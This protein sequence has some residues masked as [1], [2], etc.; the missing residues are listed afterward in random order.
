MR[1]GAHVGWKAGCV[2]LLL[3]LSMGSLA[4]P[5]PSDPADAPHTL[6]ITDRHGTT[7]RT[8]YPNGRQQPVTLHDVAPT[9]VQALIATEDRRFYHHPGIDPLSVLDAARA[10]L[11]AGRVVRG[12]STLTMQVARAM[13]PRSGSIWIDKLAEAHLALRLELRWSKTQILEAWL[14][15]VSF[16]NR[17]HG[18]EAA[19][20]LYFGTSARDLTPQQST[21]LVGL[22]QSPSRYNP[23]RYPDRARA[24]QQRVLRALV[25]S[26]TLSTADSTAWANIPLRLRPP[27]QTMRAPHFTTALLAASDA[28]HTAREW[29]TT[30]DANLQARIEARVQTRLHALRHQN[31]T[32]AAV[33]VLNNATGAIRAYVGSGDFWDANRA[34]Q[35]DGVRMHRQPGS[36]LKPFLYGAAFQ[37]GRY[38]PASILPD[39]PLHVPE[40]GGAF[41]PTNYDNRF[42]GPVSAREALAASY[43]VPAVYLAR[44]MGTA[45]L[46]GTLRDVGFA[47]L[48]RTPGHYGVGLALGNGEVQLREL[49]EAYAALARGGTRP[50]ATAYTWIRTAAGDTLHVEPPAPASTPLTPATAAQLTDMLADAEARTPAFGASTPLQLPFPVAVKTGTSK[51]YRDNWTVG[52]T[53]TH[54]VA[55]WVGNFDG[56]PMEQVSG[57]SGAGPLFHDVMRMLGPGGAFPEAAALEEADICPASGQ[58]PGA[59]CPIAR[60]ERFQPG[61]APADTC[62]VHRRIAIDR[63]TGARASAATPAFRVQE[64][65]YAVHPPAYHDW[66]RANGLPLPPEN[67]F[68][69]AAHPDARPQ[70]TY[71]TPGTRFVLDPVLRPAYQRLHL[72]GHLPTGWTDKT[73]T[74]NGAPVSAPWT[75]TP[76]RHTIVL[77]GRDAQGTRQRSAPVSIAVYAAGQVSGS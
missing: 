15:R 18:I 75:L 44:E 62:T 71:P 68:Q 70:V 6:R 66:M 42:R 39:I 29:R 9:A 58:Q 50:E 46:L 27:T 51:D 77:Y 69:T 16:G 60:A 56:S 20:Q 30:L 54:T 53:P 8:V 59:Y 52:Y 38:T 12:A 67:L 73:W 43:N 36:T 10:N 40:A 49:A 3:V 61:T 74:V 34:G 22:P 14:N 45:A 13:R 1:I 5:L 19:A 57:I 11:R 7:L 2:A 72:R 4:W 17:A 64:R 48:H 37:T 63:H 23:Y 28:D 55:V 25:E 21:F 35:N 31:V 76:G 24:R 26:G 65:T 32:N 33:L 41:T 47:S